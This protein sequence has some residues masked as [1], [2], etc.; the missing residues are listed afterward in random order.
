MSKVLNYP[1]FQ[2]EVIGGSS[3]Q[4]NLQDSNPA[5]PDVLKAFRDISTRGDY[6]GVWDGEQIRW[7][8][9]TARFE[10]GLGFSNHFQGVQRLR[11]GNYLV[12]TGGDPNEPRSHIFIAK[13]GSRY[14]QGG[15]RS[16]LIETGKPPDEDQMVR[17]IGIDPDLWHAGGI[18]VLGDIL[19]VPIYGNGKNE[20][21]QQVHAKIVFYSM[22][23]PEAP[24]RL[25]FTID[26]PGV[27][28]AA[29]ALTKLP[30]GYIL[31]AVWSDSDS[32]ERRLDFYISKSTNILDG[33]HQ[34]KVT[35]L[36]SNVQ[37]SIGQQPNFSNFQNINFITQTDGRLFLVGF[38]NTSDAAPTLPGRD[39][40][41]LYE[42]KFPSETAEQDPP[43]LLVPNI[44][45]VEN[46]QLICEDKQCNFDAAA[47]I[48]IDPNGILRL[49]ATYHWASDNIIRFNEYR[50]RPDIFSEEIH[51]PHESWIDLYEHNTF[52]G[53]CLSLR[54][55]KDVKLRDYRRINVEGHPFNDLISSVRFQLPRGKVY[56]LYEHRNFNG[57]F[58]D[59]VGTGRV[60]EIPDFKQFPASN[61]EMINFGDR[62]SSSDFIS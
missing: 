58:V 12:L 51:E 50:P 17:V 54:G 2:P 19:A 7:P 42:V 43:R 40:A 26:R 48:Y 56:R 52:Q 24:Q 11:R 32:L 27:K 22:V 55:N 4:F 20:G 44:T 60:V 62:V 3:P 41:D 28:A 39:F 13:M 38:H 47:G 49:Y 59:L 16:N 45:K 8:R 30:N 29:V 57:Q 61:G 5:I 6:L 18:S 10:N 14:A 9:Y 25:N 31:V 35:W 23:K 1:Y 33:F 37:A 36:A 34:Q 21:S 53:R 46:K 15:W